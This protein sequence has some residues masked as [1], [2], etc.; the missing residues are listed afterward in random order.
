[1]EEQITN[2][3]KYENYKEQMG[4]L[5]RALHYHFYLEAIF[6]EYAIVE[7]RIESVLR[8]SG[9]FNPE[10]HTT[11]EKKLSRLCEMQRAKNGLVRKYFSDALIQSVYDWKNRRNPLIHALMKQN[12][13]T[14]DLESV[15]LEGQALIKTL[16]TKTKAYNSML[17][18][19]SKQTEE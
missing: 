2:M 11:L 13:C 12:L 19:L 17:E 16:S 9:K 5:N 14:A 15:A 3:Q 1:M 6:I 18:K 8:H 10:K 7:D 4:R